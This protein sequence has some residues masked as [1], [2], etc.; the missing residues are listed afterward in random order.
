MAEARALAGPGIQLV[1]GCDFHLMFDNIEA[2]L[3]EPMKYTINQ[4]GYLLMELSDITIFPNTGSLW[5]Q[6]EDAG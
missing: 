4:K 5:T 3:R 2:A 6:L 1:R